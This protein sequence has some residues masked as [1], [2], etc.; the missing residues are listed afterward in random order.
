M[1]GWLTAIFN[2]YFAWRDSVAERLGK[3]EAQKA[4]KDA[5]IAA[6]GREAQAAANSPTS[7]ES[8]IA[9]Q[10]KGDV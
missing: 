10:K 4:Q 5:D 7:M 6:L 3:A 8:L 1:F 9:E 2:A